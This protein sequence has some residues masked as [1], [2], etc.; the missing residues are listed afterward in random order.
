MPPPHTYPSHAPVRPSPVTE[1]GYFLVSASKD[2][3]PMLRN[4]ETGD[5]V[6][7]FEG[8]KGATWGADLNPAATHAA[9]ASADFSCKVWDALSGEEVHQFQH[10]HICRVVKF[11]RAQE[12]LLATGSTEKA[13]RLFDLHKPDAEPEK[14]DGFPSGVRCLEWA[15]EDALLVLSCGSHPGMT[16]FDRRTLKEVHKLETVESVT[17]IEID[18]AASMLTSCDGKVI[19]FWDPRKFT[20]VKTHTMDF[21]TESASYSREQGRFAAGGEDMWVRQYDFATCEELDCNK[22]HHGP[23]H[24]V[25]YAPGGETYASGSED[26]TIRIWNT[27]PVSEEK[28]AAE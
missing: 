18:P 13:L 11:A 10:K 5:W 3:N 7:T 6:G 1:D 25:R 21:E 14:L 23:V 24:C 4:G 9:T 22:G 28:E 17:S 12:G 2:G 27:D 16:V 20:E 8:H 15:Q 19:R 26:G